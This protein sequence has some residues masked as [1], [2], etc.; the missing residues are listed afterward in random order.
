MTGVFTYRNFSLQDTPPQD[1]KV[2]VVTGGQGGVGQEITTQFLLNNIEKVFILARNKS[3]FKDSRKQ[4]THRTGF[5][6]DIIDKKLEFIQCELA[7]IRSVKEAAEHIKRNTGRV[8]I[9]ICNAGLGVST[10]YNRSPQYI[11]SVFAANCVGHQLLVT[12]LLPLLKRVTI[13]SPPSDARIVVTTSSMHMFCRR[14]DFDSLTAPDRSS[15]SKVIDAV[16]RYGRSK[17]GDI[18]LTKEL[19]RRLQEG[20]DPAGKNI[21]VNCFFP[22]NIVTEQ[23]MGWNQLFGKPIGMIMRKFFSLFIGQS[24]E[25][26]AATALYLGASDGPRKKDQRGRYFIPIATPDWPSK[27]ASDEKVARD[28]WDWIDA[29]ITQTLG[30]NWQD[31][32]GKKVGKGDFKLR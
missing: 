6:L 23:W 4:W 1:G 20:N 25:D 11:E 7:D 13:E 26:G 14:L 21:Y 32:P 2:A 16:W 27:I 8:H 5:S 12:I 31:E 24:R 3:K 22:G 28:L 18:L 29:K 30:S 9:L 15:R 10:Q 19:S 17:L